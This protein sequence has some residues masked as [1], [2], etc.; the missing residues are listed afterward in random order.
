MILEYIKVNPS[1]NTTVFVTTKVPKYLYAPIANII[2]SKEY[3]AAEQ[4]GYI[5][6]SNATE[7]GKRMEMMGGEFC[8]NASRSFAAWLVLKSYTGELAPEVS[9]KYSIPLDVS[10]YSGTLVAYVEKTPCDHSFYVTLEMPLP[11]DIKIG[12]H[13]MLGGD[14]CIVPFDGITHV[15][16]WDRIPKSDDIDIVKKYL[17]DNG[18][19]TDA[20]GVMFFDTKTDVL[21]PAVYINDVGSL[22]WE[23]SC[24]SGSTAVIAALTYKIKSGIEKT[25]HQPGG[26]LFVTSTWQNNKMQKICLSGKIDFTSEGMLF[27]DDNLL[28][29]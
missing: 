3:L 10:G 2:M 22:V 12:H 21:T 25:L 11:S 29:I 13:S 20:F 4:V 17:Q 19:A 9:G 23:N 24:G 5:V 16:L 6:E 7:S 14:F 1:G 28:D 26:D 15:I 8:G 18:I 27:I